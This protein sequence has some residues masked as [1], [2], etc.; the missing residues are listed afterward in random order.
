MTLASGHIVLLHAVYSIERILRQRGWDAPCSLRLVR[1][2][3][4][5]PSDEALYCDDRCD[6]RRRRTIGAVKAW[7]AG[8]TG[9]RGA[10]W[11]WSL[12]WR[13]DH[14]RHGGAAG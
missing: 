9:N 4:L 2:R 10:V 8:R 1:R 6:A 7:R 3:L 5:M 13:V 12:P 11:C 14:R